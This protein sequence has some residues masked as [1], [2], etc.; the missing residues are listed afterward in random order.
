MTLLVVMYTMQPFSS[1]RDRRL[2]RTKYLK[3]TTNIPA[4]LA[5]GIHATNTKTQAT[6]K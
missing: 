6:T 1:M 3:D 4:R 2:N 5:H